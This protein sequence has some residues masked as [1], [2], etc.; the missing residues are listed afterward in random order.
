MPSSNVR[1][2]GLDQ[3][4]WLPLVD[5]FRTFLVALV[6]RVRLGSL[7][8]YNAKSIPL[9]HSIGTGLNTSAQSPSLANV[10]SRLAGP[11]RPTVMTFAQSSLS[12]HQ[13]GDSA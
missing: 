11:A 10:I 13:A 9:A 2:Y 6:V 5:A 4:I 1:D 3:R 8:S 12:R 7:G